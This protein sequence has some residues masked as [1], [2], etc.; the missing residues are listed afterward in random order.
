MT[1]PKT[2]YGTEVN[3]KKILMGF[4]NFDLNGNQFTYHHQ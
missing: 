3:K 2:S 4:L 1:L